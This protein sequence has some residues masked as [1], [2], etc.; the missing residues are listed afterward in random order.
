MDALIDSL[1]RDRGILE[2]VRRIAE[3]EPGSN[4]DEAVSAQ[5]KLMAV[6]DVLGLGRKK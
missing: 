4:V 5:E 1:L 2:T 6:R 3:L